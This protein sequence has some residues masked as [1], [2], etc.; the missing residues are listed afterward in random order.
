MIPS[1]PTMTIPTLLCTASQA[2]SVF[3]PR[4]P[5]I[6]PII[7]SSNQP[8]S[9]VPSES[10]GSVREQVPTDELKHPYFLFVGRLEK[11]KGLQT[12][13]PIFRQYQKARLLIAGKGSYEPC[14]RQM[15]EGVSNIQFLGHQDDQGSLSLRRLGHCALGL[16]RCLSLSDL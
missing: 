1:P 13:I 14:L 3:S 9:F 8:T 16:L 2:R 7:R 4:W 5:R 6:K 12:L 10:S 11:L 15:A